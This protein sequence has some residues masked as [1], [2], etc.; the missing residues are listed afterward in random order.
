MSRTMTENHS[1]RTDTHLQS[2]NSLMMENQQL[3]QAKSYSMQRLIQLLEQ[4]SSSLS[5]GGN[6]IHHMDLQ[7]N[8]ILSELQ[9]R[10]KT[11]RY[12]Q[13]QRQQQNRS[14]DEQEE[15][16]EDVN[17][18]SD[19]F[20]LVSDG[21]DELSGHSRRIK[22]N[23]SSISMVNDNSLTR[24]ETAQEMV[25]QLNGYL[26]STHLD[27][28][29]KQRFEGIVSDTKSLVYK[30]PGNETTNKYLKEYLTSLESCIGGF[31]QTG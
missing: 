13:H 29:N 5:N 19:G 7:L 18:N 3:L 27:P 15:E 20:S 23:R 2:I 6:N 25:A 9:G 1:K 31:D 14:F 17:D 28:L 8:G 22:L 11:Q 16:F 12:Q 21:N 30:L 10:L 26:K 4:L 24:G